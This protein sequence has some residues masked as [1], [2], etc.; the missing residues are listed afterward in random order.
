MDYSDNSKAIEQENITRLDIIN[1]F[2]DFVNN[3]QLGLIADA[4][5]AHSDSDRNGANG[6]IPKSLAKKFSLAVD[7][8]KTGNKIILTEDEEPN[9]YP[10]Y[11][12]RER[13]SYHSNH[14]LGKLY[15][16]TLKFIEKIDKFKN[17]NNE[18][19]D[20]SLL[21][22]K[23]KQFIFEAMVFYIKYY[24]EILGILKKNDMKSESELLTGNNVDNELSGFGKKKNN[25]D[26]IERIAIQM[27][28]LFSKYKNYF[29][30]S[31]D[32]ILGGEL[33]NYKFKNYISARASAY[34]YVCYD[35]VNIIKTEEKLNE[36]MSEYF[37]QILNETDYDSYQRRRDFSN[38]LCTNSG[39][40]Y[41]DIYYAEN[42]Y[43]EEV[44][45]RISGMRENLEKRKEIIRSFIVEKMPLYK[46]PDSPN[47]E[48]EFRILSFPWCSAGDI[49]IKIKESGFNRN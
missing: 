8:P 44:E 42:Y 22:P 49:L 5:L 24:E 11:M 46:I 41:D 48:N 9:S 12:G 45:I 38:Y 30:E 3:N 32:Y 6:E 10:H 4:H 47:E 19:Y 26:V 33:N 37:N 23:F 2:A 1:F 39:G 15:D 21:V 27:K 35:F 25:H 29:N 43:I 40:D 17:L 31:S 36:M 18:F 20:N 28:E 7:A 34:Y 14:V 13:N 16:N